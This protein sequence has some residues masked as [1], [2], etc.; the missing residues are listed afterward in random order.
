LVYFFSTI[1]FLSIFCI[2][3]NIDKEEDIM[4]DIESSGKISPDKFQA[5][6]NDFVKSSN[7]FQQALS[8]YNQTTEYHK[9]AQLKKTMD[10][11][12]K[13]MNQIVR[14]GLKKSEQQMEKKVSKDYTNYIKDENPQNYKNLT[15]DLDDLQRSL[16]G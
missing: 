2:K 10:E 14:A 3:K 5:Y 1:A 8:A 7:L 13:I 9:K 15:D 16:K 4:S 6:R 12:M 11:A